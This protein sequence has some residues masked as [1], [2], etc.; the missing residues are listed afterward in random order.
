MPKTLSNQKCLSL[1]S[2]GS[3][4]IRIAAFLSVRKLA[5]SSDESIMDIILKVRPLL[6]TNVKSGKL[7]VLIVNISYPDPVLQ[8]NQRPYI[9]LYQLDEEFRF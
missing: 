7:I 2:S 4:S 3:D 9:T 6:M 1:W 8:V 5:S